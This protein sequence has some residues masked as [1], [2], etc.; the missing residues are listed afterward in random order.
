MKFELMSWLQVGDGQLEGHF[1]WAGCEMEG[2]P[3]AGLGNTVY[4]VAA[5]RTLSEAQADP[6]GNLYELQIC[7]ACLYE[8]A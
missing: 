6:E 4:D 2:C 8:H 7:L 3:S 1:S 5:Y